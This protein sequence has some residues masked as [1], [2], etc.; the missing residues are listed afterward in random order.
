MSHA[1]SQTRSRVTRFAR[2]L[3]LAAMAA[4]PLGL[5]ALASAEEVWIKAGQLLD[6]RSGKLL[7]EQ[8]IRVEDGVIRS[9]GREAVPEGAKVI[10]FSDS[11]VLPGLID[12][13]VHLGADAYSGAYSFVTISVPSQSI[14][15][16]AN[17][18]TTLK[19]G[20]TTVRS[21]G[22]NNYVDVA[23][24][25][26]INKGEVPGPRIL[27]AGNFLGMTGGHCDTN[28]L[29]Q[30]FKHRDGGVAD[31]PWA[32]RAKVRENAKYGV[33]VIKF[34]ASGGVMTKGDHPGTQELTFEEMSAMVD[35]AHRMGKKILAHAHGA[36][37]IKTAIRAGVDS[38]E[39]ASLIDAEGIRLAKQSGVAL[40]M[41]IYNDEFIR[42]EGRKAGL[43][44]E[45]LEK[46][47]LVAEAQR[48]NFRRAHRAGVKLAYG[49]DAGVYPHGQNARQ[50]SWMVKYGMSPA[51]A[52][53]A[54]TLDAAALLGLESDIGSLEAGKRADLIAVK[55]NP[56]ADV[57]VLEQVDT[58]VQSGRVTVIN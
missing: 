25:D 58:V 6:V 31:G 21:A 51:E 37:A 27:A 16:T 13:H 15:A 24:R 17:A 55:G 56:L 57:A 47:K 5:P 3:L 53:R 54:A 45:T 29:A 33:D 35:E 44:E 28:L 1:T 11:T 4:M 19:A 38:I 52:I 39:H 8:V 10:D 26:A 41:D 18:L 48:E 7:A 46:E 50:L 22:E 34:C 40:V 30:E 9:V 12:A 36:D 14:T 2:P 43:L 32:L 23:L 42:E 20:F 49:T